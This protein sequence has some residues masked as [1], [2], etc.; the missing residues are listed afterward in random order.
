[1]CLSCRTALLA[2]RPVL[3]C[4]AAFELTPLDEGVFTVFSS[5]DPHRTAN[6]IGLRLRN[7]VASGGGSLNACPMS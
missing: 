7:R 3:A 5:S 6:E 4:G 1:M 2:S